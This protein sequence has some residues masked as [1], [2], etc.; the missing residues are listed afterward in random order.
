MTADRLP[1]RSLARR[2]SHL[3][4]FGSTEMLTFCAPAMGRDYYR[5]S[6]RARGATYSGTLTRAVVFAQRFVREVE[7]G[8]LASDGSR[9]VRRAGFKS[10]GTA[11]SPG[12][13]GTKEPRG[14]GNRGIARKAFSQGRSAGQSPVR[15]RGEASCTVEVDGAV[16]IRQTRAR[17]PEELRPP[18]LSATRSFPGTGRRMQRSPCA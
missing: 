10:A 6:K 7:C 13:V 2:R 12:R 16:G 17:A 14:A 9:R 4:S 15:G 8:R 5:G 11:G 1:P 18:K 3:R